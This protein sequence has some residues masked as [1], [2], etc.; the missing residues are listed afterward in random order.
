MNAA[1]MA[2]LVRALGDLPALEREVFIAAS[3]DGLSNQ[4]IAANLRIDVAEVERRLA[5]VLIALDRAAS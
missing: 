5:A 3:V 2:R 1:A 4:Q